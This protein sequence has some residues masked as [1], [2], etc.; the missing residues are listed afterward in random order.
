MIELYILQ[1]I[2]RRILSQTPFN[3][4]SLSTIQV[5]Q[6]IFQRKTKWKIYKC[7]EKMFNFL[8]LK[9]KSRNDNTI[10]KFYL[11]FLITCKFFKYQYL[12][13]WNN[14]HQIN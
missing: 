2:E 6:F 3:S 10:M 1:K 11:V 12:F 14:V 8:I 5:Y 4:T 7:K 13:K 9:L